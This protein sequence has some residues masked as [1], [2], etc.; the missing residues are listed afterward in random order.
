MQKSVLS[1]AIAA[2]LAVPMAAQAVDVT[3]SGQVNRALFI[4]DSDSGTSAKE[5][6]NGSSGSRFRFKGTGD[7]MDG[8]SAGILL[9]Y[10][11]GGDGGAGLSLRYADLNFAGEFGK[12]SIGHGNQGGESSVYNDKSGTTGI[13]HGQDKG[14]STLGAYFGSLDGG[15]SRNGRFRYDTPSFGPVAVA[16]SVGNGDQLSAGIT[17]SQD[18]GGTAFSAAVGTVMNTGVPGDTDTVS[19]SAGVKLASGVTISGAWG[20]ATDMAGAAGTA[21]VAAIPA[22]FRSVDVSNATFELDSDAD[23]ASVETGNFDLHMDN[24]RDRIDAGAAEDA[25]AGTIADGELAKALKRALFVAAS[26]EDG[27]PCNPAADPAVEVGGPEID[28]GTETC[29]KRMYPATAGVAAVPDHVVDPSFFQATVGYVF[30]DTSVA[31]SWWQTSDFQR[32]GSEGTAVGLG[33]NHNLPKA[34]ANVYAAVQNYSVQDGAT[35]TDDTV[36][37]IGTR[38]QF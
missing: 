21:A 17:L 38:I 25:D 8:R 29:G 18:F 9:E 19:A 27:T 2:A 4:T 15:G 14:D 5:A 30:G 31:V 37:M 28:D 24:L 36:V 7:M 10:G 12:V 34:G 33:V 22:H 26:N 16:V 11:A 32:A 35:D 23:M 13:A 6:D 20:S 1:A 3:L